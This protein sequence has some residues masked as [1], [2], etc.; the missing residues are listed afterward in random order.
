MDNLFTEERKKVFADVHFVLE[1]RLRF[2]VDSRPREG[3]EKWPLRIPG[4]LF[5]CRT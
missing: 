3:R 5:L 1:S 2:L 4:G